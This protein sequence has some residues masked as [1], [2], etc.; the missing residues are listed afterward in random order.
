MGRP[1]HQP[2]REATRSRILRAAEAQFAER[3]HD[4]ARLADIARDAGIRRPSLLYWFPSKQELYDAVISEVITELGTAL[5]PLLTNENT[6]ARPALAAQAA[7]HY[8]AARP[9]VARLLLR[10]LL[11]AE[12]PGQA[13]LLQR[14]SPLLSEVATSL[15]PSGHTPAQLPVQR[16]LLTI[17]SD[18]LVFHSTPEALR[19]ALWG[20]EADRSLPALTQQLFRA[21]GAS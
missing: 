15:A 13:L 5:R 17:V 6:A 11:A 1:K 4:A 2:D 18:A 3:G 7:H 16:V 14:V 21:T 20:P 8:F 19:N 10:E 12:G 9:S